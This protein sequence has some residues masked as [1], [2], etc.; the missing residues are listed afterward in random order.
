MRFLDECP[1]ERLRQIR[2]A[3][4][5]ICLQMLIRGAN[6][7]GY[8][9]YP[10]NVVQEFIRLAAKNGM[11]VFRI[12]DCFNI[13]ENMKVSIAAVKETG[14]VAE[15]AICY[16][17]N[18]LTSSI[19]NLQ[20]YEDLAKEIQEV[21]ADIL[22]IKDMAG[23]LRPLEVEPFMAVLRKAV[24]A[25]MPIHFHTH[26]T[27]SGSLATCMEMARCGCDIIDCATASMADG[28]SQP[29]LNTF[30]AMLQGGKNDPG[31]NYLDI[32]PYDL[33]WAG[34]RE[35]YSPFE[36]GM[37]SGTARVFEHQIPGG[38][39]SNLLVQ[40]NAMGLTLEQW[41][42]VLDAYRDVNLLFGDVV[43]VTPSSKCVGDLAIY[44]VMKGLKTDDL[45]NPT[46]GDV[47]PGAHLLD[48]PSS[49]LGL[50]KGDLGFP[51]RGFPSAI[52]KLV[53]KGAAKRTTRAGI[54]LAPVNFEDNIRSLEEQ[55]QVSISAEEA[56]SSLMYPQVFADYMKRKAEKG[57]LLPLLPTPVYLYALSAGDVFDVIAQASDL[58]H[59]FSSAFTVTGHAAG[60]HIVRVELLR[61]SSIA[62][63]HRS[64]GFKLQLWNGEHKIYE[65]TQTVSVKDTGGVFV[66]EGPM[67]DTKKPMDQIGSPMS[68]T[69]EKVL[70]KEGD[71]VQA[72]DVL[73]MVS[74]MKMEVKVTAPRDGTVLSVAV[75]APGYRVVEGALLV[76]LK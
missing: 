10:D 21:G 43:K 67:V 27:S 7:V 26:S 5:N 24:G 15:V 69:V 47:Q 36:S 45:I 1:W 60:K 32:E 11:D 58:Q 59:I 22:C 35:E 6:G 19:Y 29:S 20:Y 34:V 49:I 63:V 28:T 64:V 51:H 74:A 2:A 17:G 41:S 42:A 16:T 57:P 37:K 40:A 3:C 62:H 56:M 72:G 12:F 38:Q 50:F 61:V 75:P 73:A 55:F 52:E 14:K 39:Y 4:P 25:N 53:L 71:A 70:V 9:S 54:M 31:I 23:L 46:T 44:L 8:T 68:G 13:V 48:F 18:V 66:F 76:T 65:E 33:Y 30:L